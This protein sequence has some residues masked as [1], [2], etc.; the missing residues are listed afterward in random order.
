VKSFLLQI[1][2]KG[3]KNLSVIKTQII[4]LNLLTVYNEK[5]QNKHSG[6]FWYADQSLS[7]LSFSPANTEICW[8]FLRGSLGKT[9]C[10]FKPGGEKQKI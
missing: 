9:G 10:K 7:W 6:D 1:E 2:V 8:K 4:G 5:C 3:Q